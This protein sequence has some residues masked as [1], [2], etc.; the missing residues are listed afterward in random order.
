[1]REHEVLLEE[2][3]H[4]AEPLPQ[5][6]AQ[7]HA[8]RARADRR[9]AARRS[10]STAAIV[11][12]TR[13]ASSA[14]AEVDRERGITDR[15]GLSGSAITATVGAMC[16]GMPASSIDDVER[17]AIADELRRLGELEQLLRRLLA[18]QL[19]ELGRRQADDDLAGADLVA[20]L[21][22]DARELAP[23]HRRLGDLA[24]A[25]LAAGGRQLL[26]EQLAD[27]FAVAAQR[28]AVR[29]ATRRARARSRAAAAQDGAARSRRGGATA[30]VRI[31]S[32]SRHHAA[33]SRGGGFG[34]LRD[35]ASLEEAD[36]RER[37]LAREQRIEH[38]RELAA[39]VASARAT[40]RRSAPSSRA[41]SAATRSATEIDAEI[42]R[43]DLRGD[44]R[45][46]QLAA[47]RQLGVQ[48]LEHA[49]AG[50][51]CADRPQRPAR[52]AACAARA[53]SAPGDREPSTSVRMPR[54]AHSVPHTSAARSSP[55]TTRSY[56]LLG[57]LHHEPTLARHEARRQAPEPPRGSS[58]VLL[59][60]DSRVQRGR[61]VG[62]Q[63][64]DRHLRDDRPAVEARVDEV[65]RHAGDLHA[66][67]DRLRRRIDA[68][69]RGQQRRVRVDDPQR[70]AIDEV[71]R[72]H[73]HEAGEHDEL[74][75]VRVERRDQRVLERLRDRRTPCDRR[76]SPACP[77][78]ARARAP[79]RSGRFET[80]TAISRGRE[81]A[82]WPRRRAAPA[83]SCRCRET[84][85]PTFMPR[86]PRRSPPARGTSL[87]TTRAFEPASSSTVRAAASAGTTMIMPM[88]MLNVRRISSSATPALC[89]QLR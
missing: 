2:R 78:R 4:V 88:P 75:A 59:A 89:D 40:R 72:E 41:S 38:A 20:V 11:A 82:A 62:G 61:I 87:P 86:Q 19:G 45:L 23:R 83:D 73:A 16:S 31:A 67:R 47:Q 27:R 66:V 29:R 6:R 36:A 9:R 18:E 52:P 34:E 30:R 49:L 7:R 56:E 28:T 71:R 39:R 24:G 65:N 25:Q 22:R 32:A 84:R 68:G 74:D 3:H 8:L 85:T 48:L 63:H 55:R 64:R 1:M 77:P 35:L 46:A 33:A 37:V 26:D 79:G 81:L 51:A 14:L 17:V 76:R 50:R 57:T 13:P 15:L 43:D 44:A 53:C 12:T 69:E 60:L 70:I 58:A 5:P 21:Q 42:R 54:R 80:T 10:A